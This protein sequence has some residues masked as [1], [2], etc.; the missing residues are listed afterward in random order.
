MKISMLFNNHLDGVTTLLSVIYVTE[1]E[2]K[3]GGTHGV[4]GCLVIREINVDPRFIYFLSEDG[5]TV[6]RLDQRWT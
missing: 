6:H 4:Y 5:E 1:K 2:V 3:I